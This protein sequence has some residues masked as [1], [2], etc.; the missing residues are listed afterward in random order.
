MVQ[1][2]LAAMPVPAFL[3][4]DPITDRD[5][6]QASWNC[7]VFSPSSIFL[8]DNFHANFRH[9]SVGPHPLLA[10]RPQ[11]T[12]FS[13][14]LSH[15]LD[16]L[17]DFVIENRDIRLQ[18]CESFLWRDLCQLC[19]FTFHLSSSFTSLN[20]F[21]HHSTISTEIRSSSTPINNHGDQVS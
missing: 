8:L 14:C 6:V 11:L 7:G 2:L 12:L 17:C 20:T 18:P 13:R 9:I 3:H 5:P 4:P 15:L 10:R 1:Q 21:I 16:V 19:F